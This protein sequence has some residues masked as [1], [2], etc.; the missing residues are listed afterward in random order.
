[1]A[2]YVFHPGTG[3]FFGA[4]DAEIIDV[5]ETVTDADEIEEYLQ[6]ASKDAEELVTVD[7]L[8]DLFDNQNGADEEKD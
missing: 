2:R 3:T 4:E 7:E 8:L 5:P 6:Q 1:M